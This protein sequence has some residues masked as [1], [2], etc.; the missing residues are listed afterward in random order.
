MYRGKRNLL[1]RSFVA[2]VLVDLHRLEPLLGCQAD[3]E[4][5]RILLRLLGQVLSL[6]ARAAMEPDQPSFNFIISTYIKALQLRWGNVLKA[7]MSL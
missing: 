1:R 3:G 7:S 4:G 2:A 5:F 6:D